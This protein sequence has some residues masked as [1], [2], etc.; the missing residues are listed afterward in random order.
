MNA[1]CHN[2][3]GNNACRRFVDAL[4]ATRRVLLSSGHGLSGTSRR[5]AGASSFHK[6]QRGKTM[7]RSYIRS[8]D[9]AMMIEIAPHQYVNRKVF[10]PRERFNDRHQRD[11]AA[12][13]A[14]DASAELAETAVI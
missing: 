3:P 11:E 6:T 4:P 8:S 9:D 13:E 12:V 1:D 10:H 5:V 2:W 14:E 7:S